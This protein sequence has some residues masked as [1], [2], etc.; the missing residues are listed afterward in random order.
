M[1]LII[2]VKV[3]ILFIRRPFAELWPI[4]L[5]RHSGD[6]ENYTEAS[7]AAAAAA[8]TR[9][10]RAHGELATINDKRQSLKEADI[11]LPVYIFIQSCVRGSERARNETNCAQKRSQ[12]DEHI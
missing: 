3:T 7:D 11:F 4:R 1:E 2:C 10:R 8:H 12:C 6:N 5:A 9:T